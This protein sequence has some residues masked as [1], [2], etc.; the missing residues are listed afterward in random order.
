MEIKK[1]IK[2]DKSIL[3][4]IR[5][6]TNSNSNKVRSTP[7]FVS[8]LLK[9]KEE[10]DLVQ[11]IIENENLVK[12][13][14]SISKSRKKRGEVVEDASSVNFS[15]VKKKKRGRQ[16]KK[17]KKEEQED[18]FAS[19]FE[20]DICTSSNDDDSEEEYEKIKSKKD[21]KKGYKVKESKQSNKATFERNKDILLKLIG[22]VYSNCIEV[23]KKTVR[24]CDVLLEKSKHNDLKIQEQE[25]NIKQIESNIL[26]QF[27]Q[28]HDGVL[29]QKSPLVYSKRDI[30][31]NEIDT[32]PFA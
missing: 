14:I 1:T 17:I 5:R 21:D 7:P 26:Q 31:K 18:L 27:R 20:D 8:L 25:K 9:T 23:S 4:K 11:S 2:K 30:M 16:T 13:K 29:S 10:L 6:H 3:Q 32:N 19:D 22:D 24:L 12:N 28:I 15:I